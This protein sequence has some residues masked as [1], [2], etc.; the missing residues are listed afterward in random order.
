L[1][2]QAKTCELARVETADDV[3]RREMMERKKLEEAAAAAKTPRDK[4]EEARAFIE[5]L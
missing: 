5:P 4:K 3:K 2:P 1:P